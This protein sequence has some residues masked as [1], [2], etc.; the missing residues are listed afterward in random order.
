MT[1]TQK[2]FVQVIILLSLFASTSNFEIW[3]FLS[4]PMFACESFGEKVLIAKETNGRLIPYYGLTY[5]FI[6]GFS[7]IETLSNYYHR[8]EKEKL[9]K[10][11]AQ[12]LSQ[13]DDERYKVWLAQ[14][15]YNENGTFTHHHPIKILN[16]HNE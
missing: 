2:F 16:D 5:S 11:S 12:V 6:D 15:V 3:P 14:P 9:R 4:Y 8:N 7:L 13:L 10:I 1:L